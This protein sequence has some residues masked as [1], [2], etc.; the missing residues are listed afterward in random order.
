MRYWK[1]ITLQWAFRLNLNG[2]EKLCEKKNHMNNYI[3]SYV[4]SC[5]QCSKCR[6]VNIWYV[7]LV[8][9]VWFWEVLGMHLFCIAGA[10]CEVFAT[11]G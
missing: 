3:K 9:G 8:F 6:F 11:A 10:S 5:I 2:F 4:K 1:V 7:G